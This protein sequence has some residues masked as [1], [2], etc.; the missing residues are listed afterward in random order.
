MW[1]SQVRIWLYTCSTDLQKVGFG[2]TGQ[3]VSPIFVLG[4]PFA[5]PLQGSTSLQH[6][7]LDKPLQDSE[8][9]EMPLRR[10]ETHGLCCASPWLCNTFSFT[11]AEAFQCRIDRVVLLFHKS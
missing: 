1:S 5:L 2:R 4:F 6:M 3:G 11:S 7:C 9:A 10:T 8:V